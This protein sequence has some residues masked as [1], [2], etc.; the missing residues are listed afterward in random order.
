MNQG[1]WYDNVLS[2]GKHDQ[3]N[4]LHLRPNRD[5]RRKNQRERLCKETCMDLS[6]AILSPTSGNFRKYQQLTNIT[7]GSVL[8][9]TATVW[10]QR[11]SKM[12]ATN[13]EVSPREFPFATCPFKTFQLCDKMF[14]FK[15]PPKHFLESKMLEI[16]DLDA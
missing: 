12:K 1:P 9:P 13:S 11:N 15:L 8:Y 5:Q 10:P 6:V 14:A 7:Y 4:I 3:F 16:Q 2:T